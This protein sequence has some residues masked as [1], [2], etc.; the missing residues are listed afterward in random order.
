MW[1]LSRAAGTLQEFRPGASN[2]PLSRVARTCHVNEPQRVRKPLLWLP[3][4]QG[5]GRFRGVV[6][7]RTTEKKR[8][9]Q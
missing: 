5:R 9:E 3:G 2:Q 1:L 8:G 6:V 7:V 4:A